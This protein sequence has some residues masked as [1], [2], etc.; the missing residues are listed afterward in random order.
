MLDTTF[1]ITD[2][3][4]L[5]RTFLSLYALT[6]APKHPIMLKFALTEMNIFRLTN[7]FFP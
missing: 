7:S 2:H 3:A 1:N 4:A 5:E 6:L